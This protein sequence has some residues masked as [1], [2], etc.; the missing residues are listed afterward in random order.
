MRAVA[1]H[2]QWIVH[3]VMGSPLRL[4]PWSAVG[5]L[6]VFQESH[7]EKGIDGVMNALAHDEEVAEQIFDDLTGAG[8]RAAS[9]N[10]PLDEH[11]WKRIRQA[12]GLGL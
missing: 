3:P 7:S 8:G 12:F 6:R 4:V 10:G 2:R 5:S 9:R 1:R 11:D